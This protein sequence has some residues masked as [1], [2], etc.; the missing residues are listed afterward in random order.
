MEMALSAGTLEEGLV[1]NPATPL[2]SRRC[3]RIR[4]CLAPPSVYRCFGI[5]PLSSDRFRRRARLSLALERS[6]ICPLVR[7]GLGSPTQKPS[8]GWLSTR[9]IAGYFAYRSL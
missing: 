5:P 6:P 1:L 2:A 9:P 8:N 4:D 7:S 3:Y